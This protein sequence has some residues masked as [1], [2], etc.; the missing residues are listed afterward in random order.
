MIELNIKYKTNNVQTI[1]ER[2]IINSNWSFLR[3]DKRYVIITDNN[4][5]KN[6]QDLLK[7]IPNAITVLTIKEG[8]KSKALSIYEKI[9]KSLIE[10]D[11]KKDDVLIAFGGGIVC[12]LTGFVAGTYLKGIEY[13]N[14]PTSL[15][16]QVSAAIGGNC[17]LYFENTFNISINYHPSSII[18]DPDI[19]K[20]LPENEFNKGILEIIKYG[21]IKDSKIFNALLKEPLTLNSANL[22]EI[23]I[24]CITYKNHL[25]IKGEGQNN[26][27]ILNYG[28]LYINVIKRFFPKFSYYDLLAFSMFYELNEALRPKILNIYSLYGFDKKINEMLENQSL[29]KAINK[30]K[31]NS[32]IKIDKIGHATIIN[33]K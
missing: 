6:Y 19:L 18:I 33:E 31:L 24:N 30:L 26:N 12:E 5:L 11:I 3:K 10:I 28:L 2:G 4:L 9:I 25:L 27:T 15:T 32:N 14:I 23:I 22:L 21:V 7:T 20:T 16:A 29:E 1:V 8:I 13:I 17:S